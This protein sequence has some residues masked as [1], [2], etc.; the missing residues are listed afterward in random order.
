[1]E[2]IIQKIDDASCHPDSLVRGLPDRHGLIVLRSAYFDSPESRYSIVAKDPF[3]ECRFSGNRVQKTSRNGAKSE[4][5]GNPWN[6]LSSLLKRYKV[7]CKS[8]LPLPIGGCFGFWGYEL[9]MYGDP[10]LSPSKD[11]ERSIPDAHVFFYD[12][13]VIHDHL[14]K[15]WWIVSTGL[16]EDGSTDPLKAKKKMEDWRNCLQKLNKPPYQSEPLDRTGILKKRP[17]SLPH[18]ISSSVTA[19]EFINQVKEV[20]KYIRQ[21]DIYQVNLSHRLRTK[22]P[23]SGQEFFNRLL[24]VSPAPFS[25]YLNFGSYQLASSSPESFLR[26]TGSLIRTSPIKGTRPRGQTPSEDTLLANE[27]DQ[28]SKERSELVMITDLM[29]NDLGKISCYGSVKVKDLLRLHKFPRVQHLISTIEA[30]LKPEISHM[31]ALESCFPGGSITGAPKIRAMEIIEEIEPISRE[32][33]TGC[34]GYLGFN[35]ES[36]FSISI[37]TAL[38]KDGMIDFFVGAGI[39]HDSD[40]EAEYDETL[41]KAEGFFQALR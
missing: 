7:T 20:Q 11:Y 33:Y 9:R 21:G 26:M 2:P 38:V 3:L 17:P 40:P 28:S 34:I 23:L 32:Y 16:N 24:A 29:R 15:D 14:T 5:S 1:M 25:A 41:T 13:L 12:N 19:Q 37:R 30:R 27:L 22:C 39:V 35:E 36:A 4:L 10:I 31:R 8:S 18:G 6:I